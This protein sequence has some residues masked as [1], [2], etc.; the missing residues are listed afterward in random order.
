LVPTMERVIG[1]RGAAAQAHRRSEASARTLNWVIGSLA[2]E[3]SIPRLL[4]YP[5]QLRR[6]TE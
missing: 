6:Y 3:N 4:N 2:I 1:P 5:I